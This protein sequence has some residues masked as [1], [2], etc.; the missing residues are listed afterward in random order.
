MDTGDL[1]LRGG[2]VLDP[3]AQRPLDQVGDVRISNGR[4]VEIGRGLVGHRIL[5]VKDLWVVPGL[6][7][8]HV[9]LREPGQEYKEDIVVNPPAAAARVPVSMSSL[10]C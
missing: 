1:V 10:Y 9:H 4:V 2:R 5:D 7:D 8:L 6:I 3:G